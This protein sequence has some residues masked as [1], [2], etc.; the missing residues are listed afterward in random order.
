MTNSIKTIN[1]KNI[2][3]QIFIAVIAVIIASLIRIAF[4][5][6]LENKIPWI[7]FYP[8]VMVVAMF[9]GFYIG[10]L[11]AILACLINIFGWQYFA[12]TPFINDNADWIG[13]GVFL[14][15]CIFVSLIAEYSRRQRAKATK[16]KEHAEMANK[17]KSVFLANMSHELRTPLNAILGFT[18]LMK[19]NSSIPEPEQKNLQIVNQ[20]GEH[21]LN[22]INNILDLSKIEAGVTKV[23]IAPFNLNNTLH[24]ITSIM[25]QRAESKGLFLETMPSKDLPN[26]ILSDELK[27]KQILINLL[28]NA[29]K[30]TEH[31]SIKFIIN[32]IENQQNEANLLRIEV[33]DTGNGISENYIDKIFD[34]FVQ[35]GSDAKT[36]GTGLGLTICRQFAELLNGNITVESK[37]GIGSLFTVTLPYKIAEQTEIEQ[38]N[39]QLIKSLAPTEQE[40]RILIVE[41]HLENWMLLQ[42]ILESVGFKVN[43]TENGLDGIEAFKNFK[44]NLIFMDVRMPIM[45]GLE[46]T[47][48]IRQ[49][50]NGKKVKIIGVSAHVFKDEIQSI[51]QSGMD[52][53][54]KKPYHFNDIYSSL[55]KHLNVKFLFH[56]SLQNTQQEHIPLTVD[57]IKSLDN[58]VLLELKESIENLDS[59]KLSDLVERISLQNK[60]LG[61]VLD[62]YVSNYKT[63]EIFRL[64]KDY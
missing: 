4:L 2:V 46:A 12:T 9:G 11:S 57:M 14:L 26:Y 54:I 8:A 44:P 28:G 35:V 10:L 52:D 62:Y 39:Y 36:K 30:F 45:D 38:T 64:L 49:L 13:L 63:T 19:L 32:T 47:R 17:A 58:E 60:E 23:N 29:I 61:D 7:T 40:Y 55:Q 53:F 59:V 6:L 31:G 25:S 21:L 24:N 37:L 27:L 50:E 34:P 42:R 1:F 43:V 5:G 56:S 3:Q 41:D 16:A 15:N 20:S 18:N 51:L 33:Q 48:Q 22:L